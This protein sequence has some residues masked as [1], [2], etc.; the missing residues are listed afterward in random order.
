MAR[1]PGQ[2][3]ILIS[4]A[5]LGKWEKTSLSPLPTSEGCPKPL[6]LQDLVWMLGR[7][8]KERRRRPSQGTGRTHT[9]SRRATP[10]GERALLS[11]SR[12]VGA[13]TGRRAASAWLWH[14]S[15]YYEA[16]LRSRSVWHGCLQPIW[17]LSGAEGG[18]SAGRANGGRR[19]DISGRQREGST[20]R[21]FPP[22]LVRSRAAKNRAKRSE[23][24]LLIDDTLFAIAGRGGKSRGGS[25]T[26][27]PPVGTWGAGE[28][29]LPFAPFP[30]RPLPGGRAEKR[31]KAMRGLGRAIVPVMRPSAG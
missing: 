21:S 15:W 28:V 19:D 18:I 9:V 1:R 16:S 8:A 7:G 14:A 17:Q 10:F 23:A 2:Y 20:R 26:G 29:H 3:H 25:N 27:Q 22:H 5:I 11:G 31:A 4:G 13:D 24:T 6:A 30:P 12:P